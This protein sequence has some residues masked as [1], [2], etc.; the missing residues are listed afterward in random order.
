M[1]VFTLYLII[2][3]P[4]EHINTQKDSFVLV[5][6]MNIIQWILVVEI[7]INFNSVNCID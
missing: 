3:I 7:F 5:F 6:N 1:V 4:V 2:T